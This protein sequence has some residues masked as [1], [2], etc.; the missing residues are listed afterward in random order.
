EDGIRDFHVTGVQTCALPIF[1]ASFGVREDS[2]RGDLGSQILG[3]FL[4]VVDTHADQQQQ[5]AADLA[6]HFAVDR[7][8]RARDALQ[9]NPHPRSP[10]SATP[11]AATPSLRPSAASRSLGVAL[12]LT[13]PTSIPRAVA[14]AARISSRRAPIIGSSA[15]TVTSTL[16]IA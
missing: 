6:H 4:A 5:S 2:Q 14:S 11:R 10:T 16:P 12:T 1:H 9:Q 8:R 13:C 3:L 15:I 7:H